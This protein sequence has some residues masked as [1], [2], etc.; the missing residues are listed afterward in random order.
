MKVKLGG[1]DVGYLIDTGSEVSTTTEGFYK[2]FLAQ[3]REV[4]KVTS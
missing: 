2:E 1:V 4:I 3:G